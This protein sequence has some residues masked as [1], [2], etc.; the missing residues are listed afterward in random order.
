MNK[1][2]SLLD[3]GYLEPYRDVIEGRSRKAFLRAEEL[4]GGAELA[5]WANAHHYFG[6]HRTE[7]GWEAY[8]TFPMSF[9][10]LFF[11][12]CQFYPGKKLR[13]NLYK[14]GDFTV[15]EHYIAW[16]PMDPNRPD[17]HLPEYFGE[18]TLG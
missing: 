6:L 12:G 4:T 14:C 2:V 5:Q 1:P 11:P 15:Q 13:A 7:D 9:V 16:N 18:M 3:D 8:Y 17:Y 10:H